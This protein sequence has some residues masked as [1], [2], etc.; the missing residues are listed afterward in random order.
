MGDCSGC[1]GR[2]CEAFTFWPSAAE[3]WDAWLARARSTPMLSEPAAGRT[4]REE[5]LYVADMLIPLG[6]MAIPELPDEKPQRFT[7]KHFD[8]E[9]R[10]C[11]EYELRP[12][13]CRDHGNAENRCGFG[14]DPEPDGRV[15]RP[16][17]DEP[18]VGPE[19]SH[20]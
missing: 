13:M 20:G 12:V 14:C 11:R 7:C 17:D 15:A 9:T 19:V 10:R 16:G 8:T 1:T 18:A 5:V 2:C 4:A 3:G 6:E